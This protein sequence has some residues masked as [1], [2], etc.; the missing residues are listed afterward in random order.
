MC[1]FIKSLSLYIYIHTHTKHNLSY[2]YVIINHIY[3]FLFRTN[4]F[5]PN[6]TLIN[7]YIYIYIHLYFISLFVNIITKI[8]NIFNQNDNESSYQMF[9]HA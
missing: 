4:I 1:F 3:S 5:I 2:I 7:L 8:I 6:I 9:R